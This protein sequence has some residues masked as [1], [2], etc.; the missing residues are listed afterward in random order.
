MKLS[1]TGRILFWTGG[2][3]WIGQSGEP[4]DFHAHHA[5]Q[6][7]L[8]LSDGGV[9]FRC[10]GEDW[11]THTAAI[12]AANQ[13]HAFAGLGNIVAM[14]FVEPESR[15]GQVLQQR[16]CGEGIVSIT[17]GTLD[18]EIA[19]LF[20]CY[21]NTAGDSTLVDAARAVIVRLA[22]TGN[23]TGV[24]LDKRIQR[25]I[26][27]MRERIGGAVLLAD[28]AEATC[29][30]P[31]RFRHLFVEETGIRFRPYVLWLRI[32]IALAAYAA[33]KSLTEASHAGGFADSA[34]FSRTFRSMFGIAPS[35][36]Q[37]T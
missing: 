26:E 23:V 9:R 20:A 24:A 28:I 22:S 15:Y 10:H 31:D 36:I 2:S 18:S 27:V 1:G 29:L 13:L 19:H 3:I 11:N 8:S 12:I 6:I 16:C 4:A 25:A 37:I 5:V 17:A 21:Q 7:A 30:S 35:S 34:H 14:V 33:S 32:E